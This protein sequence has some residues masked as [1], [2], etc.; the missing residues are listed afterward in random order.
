MISPAQHN[1]LTLAL[2]GRDCTVV[3]LVDGKGSQSRTVGRGATISTCVRRGWLRR[4]PDIGHGGRGLYTVT[5]S[6]QAI[7]ARA[8]EREQA[9]HD[10]ALCAGIRLNA[11]WERGYRCHGLW[12]AASF[13]DPNWSPSWNVYRLGCVSLGPPGLWDGKTYSWLVDNPASQGGV[14]LAEGEAG[15]LKEA[16]QAVELAVA[17]RLQTLQGK[18]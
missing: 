7:L 5:E 11:G 2:A 13:F 9:D 1:V 10:R 17:R 8:A 14:P 6:G 3:P 12:T 15:S 4:S 18:A 16:K